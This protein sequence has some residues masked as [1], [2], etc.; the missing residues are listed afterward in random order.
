MS[1]AWPSRGHTACVR[2]PGARAA[3]MAPE[4]SQIPG[5]GKPPGPRLE[6]CP[7]PTPAAGGARPSPDGWGPLGA[8]RAPRPHVIAPEPEPTSR[9]R[10]RRGSEGPCRRGGAGTGRGEGGPAGAGGPGEPGRHGHRHGHRHAR[11]SSR[12]QGVPGG[13]PTPRRTEGVGDAGRPPKAATGQG[14][15]AT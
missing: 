15:G 9:P 7:P 11:T 8:G 1:K 6:R 14:R 4:Q 2:V 10:T 13:S 5:P 3:Y 12:A